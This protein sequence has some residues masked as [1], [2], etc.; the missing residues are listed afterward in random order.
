LLGDATKARA[1]LGW[2]PK[3]R[4][5]ELVQMMIDADLDRCRALAR[6]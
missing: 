2:L 6:A 4:F 5:P 1:K 3:V